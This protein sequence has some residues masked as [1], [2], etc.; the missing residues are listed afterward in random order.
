K[1]LQARQP[2][3]LE[4]VLT[5][6]RDLLSLR[7]ILFNAGDER[8]ELVAAHADRAPDRIVRR[9]DLLFGEC[10]NPRACVR[11]IAV[12]QRSVHIEDHGGAAGTGRQKLPSPSSSSS[13]SRSS[14]LSKSSSGDASSIS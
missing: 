6:F 1:W 11:V 9:R 12:D 13:S 4:D 10:L 3:S 7:R 14:G 2:E 5:P 8:H